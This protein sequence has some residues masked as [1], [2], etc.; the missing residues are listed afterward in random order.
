MPLSELIIRSGEK[1][2]NTQ[3]DCHNNQVPHIIEKVS[4]ETFTL[5][6]QT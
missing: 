5:I 6:Y 1:W 3:D 4:I 2:I